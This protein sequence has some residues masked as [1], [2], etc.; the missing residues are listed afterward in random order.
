MK[1]VQQ[2]K[3]W[4]KSAKRRLFV[5]EERTRMS[6]RDY[7]VMLAITLIYAVVAFTNLGAHD[8]PDTY[9][10]MENA[11]E[12]ITV[13]FNEPEAI[14]SIKYYTSLGNGQFSFSYSQDG[15]GYEP[16]LIENKTDEYDEGGQ[17]IYTIEPFSIDHDAIG[18]YEW[19]FKHP[20]AFTAKYVTINVDSPGVRIL[21]M[22]FCG[23][24][25]MP[26]AIKSVN[27]TAIS[28][29][30]GNPASGMFDEQ[31]HV[32]AQT[33]YMTEMYF[34]EVYHAR[35]AFE[36]INH[37]PP[38]E[39][40]HPPLGKV[41]LSIGI[42]VF[43]M[44]PFGWRFM[45]TLFGV[46][47]LP[48]MYLFAKRLFKQT[49]FAFIPTFLFAVDFMHFSQT[50]IATIDSYSLFF[51][52]LMYYFM[53]RYT[54]TNYNREPLG[55]TLIPLALCGISFGLGAATKWLCIYAGLGLAVLLFIQIGK[56]WREYA[57]V[58]GV[59]ANAEQREAMDPSKRGYFADIMHGFT[60]RTFITLLWCVLFFIVVPIIIYV[61][62]YTPY[63]AQATDTAGYALR[64]FFFAA[65]AGIVVLLFILKIKDMRRREA[66]DEDGEPKRFKPGAKRVL[67]AVLA[68]V[69][70]IAAV[71]ALLWY[72]SFELYTDERPYD[73]KGVLGNQEYMWNYHSDLKTDKPHP[74][75]SRWYSWPLN[76]R[77]VFLF[78]GEGY[79]DEYMSS[80]STMGNPAVWWG[81][82]GAVITLVVI[83]LRRGKL[84]KR[85][86]FL[87]VAAASQFVPW[88]VISRETFIYH[89]FETIPFLILLTAV[90]A[91]Y[92]IER[93]KYGK[94]AV[95][96]FLAVCLLLFVMFY[97][98]T[99]GVV[100]SRGY[101]NIIRWLP[102]WPFY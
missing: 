50:R 71:W 49:L 15:E 17:P 9:F 19:Q 95:F 74:F 79:P 102:S 24:D 29:E 46:L 18:M 7:L 60:K 28:P 63:M 27:S 30:R 23:E 61:M 16:V 43:G 92:L 100:I 6:R 67:L 11:G 41:F 94:K 66:A 22:G 58:E 65:T 70:V 78:Q 64:A 72:M 54:E 89:Y 35:T 31:Y 69:L 75:Q 45:G 99:T 40:T 26:V 3:N 83:R 85:T 37:I 12:E 14:H 53:Y 76:I 13:E 91:K 48:L 87:G 90:L 81:A 77:P 73:L 5:D 97:P 59:L 20:Q 34:D 52:M 101:A 32:P 57:Y 36:H 55:R 82:L 98:V 44:N 47:L 33:Y 51:V 4:Q 10:A 84:G 96:A 42:Q 56:R 8:I 93:T 25:G 68:C 38:Y 21:E 39:I 2:L 62:A 80:M 86:F 1:E 88:V